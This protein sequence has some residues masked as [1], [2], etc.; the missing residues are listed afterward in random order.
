MQGINKWQYNFILEVF[1]LY[2]SIK[3]RVNFLQLARYGKYCEQRYRGQ[4]ERPIDFLA[5]NSKLIRQHGS[6]HYTIAFDPSHISKSGK[7]TPGVGW[8]WSGCAGKAKWGLEIGGIGVIDIDNHTGFHLEAVQTP[9]DLGPHSLVD[10]YA[11]V[12]IQRKDTLLPVSPYVVADGYF[13][14]D[15]FVRP[16]CENGFDVVSRLRDDADLRY[17]Y[18]GEQKKGR[19]RPRKHNGKVDFSALKREY[20]AAVTENEGQKVY[21][22]IV[23]SKALKRDINLVIEYNLNKKGE[24]G[25]KLYFSTDLQLPPEQLLKYYRTRFQIEFTFRDAKQFTGLEHSQARSENKLYSHFN[26]SLTTVNLA[27]VTHWLTIPKQ[28]REAFS[29][30]D[31]KTIYHNN[32]LLNRFFVM[33]GI[34]P[35]LKKNKHKVTELLYYGARAA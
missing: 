7:A 28:E 16:L 4:F 35:D 22:A 26:Y 14:K 15:T 19:G 11:Q 27:K 34:Q 12:I 32:L 21:H 18:Q 8:Y 29:M 10:H 20:F 30:A 25:H 31:V 17:K 3:G 6:G 33:F 23:Y 13:S 1:G 9:N 5:F 2:L 24:W